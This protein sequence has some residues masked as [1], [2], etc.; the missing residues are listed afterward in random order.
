MTRET[1]G[2]E[3]REKKYQSM[4]RRIPPPADWIEDAMN[5]CHHHPLFRSWGTAMEHDR[6]AFPVDR[7]EGFG[8][9]WTELMVQGL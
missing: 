8:S 4:S 6:S 7:T 2:A 9:L 5:A 3:L 1:R